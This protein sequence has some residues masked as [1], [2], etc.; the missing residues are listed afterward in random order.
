MRNPVGLSIELL[1][2][3]PPILIENGGVVGIAARRILDDRTQGSMVAK[4]IQDPARLD[5]IGNTGGKPW[6]LLDHL[7]QM[8][9]VGAHETGSPSC[10]GRWREIN[11]GIRALGPIRSAV[12]QAKPLEGMEG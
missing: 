5:E 9:S 12:G 8:N 10:D 2:G 7:A 6:G 1:V 11:G 4:G 3:V